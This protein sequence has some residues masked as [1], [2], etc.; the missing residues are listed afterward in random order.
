MGRKRTKQQ[1]DLPEMKGPGVAQETIKAIEEAA[2][3]YVVV[4]D[5]RLKLAE[6]EADAGAALM[7]VVKANKERLGTNP[8]GET[9]YRYG[10][11]IVTLKPVGEKV[12]VRN[13]QQE[14]ELDED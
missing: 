2:D 8:D 12:R 1:P 9:I 14:V 3:A 5:R 7:A 4:R 10:S 13:V 11:R 6:Q